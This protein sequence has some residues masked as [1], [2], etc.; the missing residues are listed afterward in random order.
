MPRWYKNAAAPRH[1]KFRPLIV[2]GGS[3][4]GYTTQWP[5]AGGVEQ[6]LPSPDCNPRM[7]YLLQAKHKTTGAVDKNLPTIRRLGS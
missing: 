1:V 6:P 5:T 7:A 3:C 4:W 2:N